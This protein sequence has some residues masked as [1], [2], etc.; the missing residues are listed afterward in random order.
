MAGTD[1][2]HR[3]QVEKA[4]AQRQIISGL[5]APQKDF[6]ARSPVKVDL[7]DVA[8]L[9]HVR[10][11]MF[12]SVS[13]PEDILQRRRYNISA[14]ADHIESATTLDVVPMRS[15]LSDVGRESILFQGAAGTQ[16]Y[17][18][19]YDFDF[20]PADRVGVLMS[21]DGKIRGGVDMRE[22]PH[23]EKLFGELDDPEA[24]DL[25]AIFEAPSFYTGY[26]VDQNGMVQWHEAVYMMPMD[27]DLYVQRDLETKP[28][29]HRTQGVKRNVSHTRDVRLDLYA[30]V[31]SR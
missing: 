18:G 6:A 19:K 1:M 5:H 11:E 21:P 16:L 30:R 10:M 14:L 12:G 9:R 29:V 3:A 26:F 2:R 24:L 20:I 22:L 7:H 28:P 27:V 17:L 31:I 8:V 25:D 13:M 4:V 23:Q 15:V